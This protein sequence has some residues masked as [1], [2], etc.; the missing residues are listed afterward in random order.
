MLSYKPENLELHSIVTYL[1]ELV[2]TVVPPGHPLATVSKSTGDGIIAGTLVSLTSS[3]QVLQTF[4]PKTPPHGT[5]SCPRCKRSK[6]L[7]TTR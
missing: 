1:D 2:L 3:R 6:T 5:L 7:V 4:H